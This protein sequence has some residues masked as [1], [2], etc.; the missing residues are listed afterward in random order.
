[1]NYNWNTFIIQQEHTYPQ[2]ILAENNNNRGKVNDECE[3]E[4]NEE[5]RQK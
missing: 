4:N 5:K 3:E 1:M 2:L